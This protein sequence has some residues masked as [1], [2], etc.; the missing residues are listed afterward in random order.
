MNENS[1]VTGSL[2]IKNTKKPRESK[3]GIRSQWL[4][5][6]MKDFGNPYDDD[7]YDYDNDY[8]Y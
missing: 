1:R 7:D 6:W 2:S 8:D 4:K 3:W 5:D